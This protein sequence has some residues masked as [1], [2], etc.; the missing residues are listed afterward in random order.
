VAT[1]VA[2]RG[3]TS[4]CFYRRIV[5]TDHVQWAVST[6]SSSPRRP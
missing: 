4:S 3:L 1:E 5:Y 6:R 2:N